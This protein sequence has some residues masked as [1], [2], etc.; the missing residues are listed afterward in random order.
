MIAAPM[1]IPTIAI[2]VYLW[3]NF[4]MN[5]FDQLFGTDISLARFAVVMGVSFVLI[6]GGLVL[7]AIKLGS[8]HSDLFGGSGSVGGGLVSGWDSIFRHVSTRFKKK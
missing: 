3:S 4:L 6:V 5:A 7:G 8:T 1:M 2:Y